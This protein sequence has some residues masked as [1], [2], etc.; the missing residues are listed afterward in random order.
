MKRK[1]VISENKINRLLRLINESE[2]EYYPIS[3]E[4]FKNLLKLSGNHIEG[5]SKL[6]RFNGK[7]LKITGSLDLRSEP[8][9]TLGNIGFVDGSLDISNTKISDISNV[10]VKG[11]VWDSNTPREARRLARELAKKKGEGEVRRANKEWDIDDTDN[12]GLKA[13]AL[14]EWLVNNSEIEL[15]SDEDRERLIELNNELSTLEDIEEPTEEVVERISEI[16]DEISDIGED[17]GDV[18]DLYPYSQH[19]GLTTFEV[20]LPGFRNR[21][22]SVG[23]YDEMDEAALTYAKNYINDVGVEGFNKHFLEDYIDKD[24][25]SDYVRDWYEDDVWQNPEVY[26]NERDFELTSEQES[27][28]EELEEYIESLEEYIERMES[29]Q[30][31][32]EDEIEE[33]EEYSQR[34]DEI[35][36]MIDDAESKK[37]KAQDELDSI[38]PDTEPDQE[39]V[40][41]VVQSYIDDALY[42][43]SSFIKNHGLE[44]RN[45]IDEDELAKGLVDTDGWGVMN[46]YDGNYDEVTIDGTDYYIM[47]VS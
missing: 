14:F 16:E 36:K 28:I 25:L 2:D 41:G 38:E 23:T 9:K 39:M 11:H 35:Q 12:E 32:L 42:D 33:P 27:R 26:F 1:L 4:E 5:I 45:F 6:P 44:I 8:Y 10:I 19:Y 37:E 40:D 20:L 31:D 17:E 46:G 24:Y 43:P 13:N 47:R 30:S 3:P 22:Y 15:I 21:E 29:E 7:K 34:Y 18:Y